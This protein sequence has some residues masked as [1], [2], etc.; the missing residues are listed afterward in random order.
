MTRF[1]L[2]GAEPVARTAIAEVWKVR[3]QT[4][5]PAALKIYHDGQFDGEAPGVIY[6]ASL[7]GAAAAHV[8]DWVPGAVLSEW[9]EGPPLK[10]LSL[11]GQDTEAN[12]QLAKVALELRLNVPDDLHGLTSLEHRFRALFAVRFDPLCPPDV[13][14]D[15]RRATDIARH[16]LATQTDIS[17]LHGDLHH[18]N[19]RFGARGWCAFDAKGL[20]GEWAYEL[21]NAFRNPPDVPH[22][23]RSPGRIEATARKWAEMCSLEQTRL[24]SWAA[25]KCALSIAW[26][27]KG[28]L[29]QDKETDLLSR[30]LACLDAS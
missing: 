5:E 23:V 8:N 22:L 1:G 2:S 17:P 18:D 6:L 9:L 7:N 25:A 3:R 15:M 29:I 13:T 4:G 27:A 19:I 16:L 10:D 14:A 24:L 21:A 12:M 30:L 26:R 11:S 20:V 28:T